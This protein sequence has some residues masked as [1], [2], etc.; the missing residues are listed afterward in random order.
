MI[1]PPHSRLGNRERRCLKN[2]LEYL[3]KAGHGKPTLRSRASIS[4]LSEGREHRLWAGVVKEGLLQEVGLE[5]MR[6]TLQAQRTLEMFLVG[7]R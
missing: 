6:R 4:K 7:D 2:K 3:D 5:M 1:T